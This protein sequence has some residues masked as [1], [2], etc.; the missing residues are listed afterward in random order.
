MVEKYE[1]IV[2]PHNINYI[3]INN[4][5]SDYNKKRTNRNDVLRTFQP[6]YYCMN[7]IDIGILYDK[8]YFFKAQRDIYKYCLINE[9]YPLNENS[10]QEHLQNNIRIDIGN[11]E[12]NENWKI[13]LYT[14]T[15]IINN[16]INIK[17]CDELNNEL[18]NEFNDELNEECNQKYIS[19]KQICEM[20]GI[21]YNDIVNNLK[22]E[23]YNYYK[24]T[25]NLFIY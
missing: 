17:I 16:E 21:E 8:Q 12:I 19:L 2:E 6:P 10:I 25:P 23:L 5:C 14:S 22:L 1:M 18:N 4:L 15:K 13:K 7:R 3:Y 24:I 20:N 11:D 9:L